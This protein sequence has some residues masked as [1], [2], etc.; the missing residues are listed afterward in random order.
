MGFSPS[1]SFTTLTLLLALPLGAQD[2][3]LVRLRRDLPARG[4]NSA[5]K[6]E[7]ADRPDLRRDWNLWWFGG[8]LSPDYLDYKNRLAAREMK[9]WGALMPQATGAKLLPAVLGAA[10]APAGT[11]G[12]WVNLGPTANLTNSTWPDHDSGRPSAIAVDPTSNTLYLATSGGGVWKCANADPAAATAWTWTPITDGLPNSGSS[13]NVSVGALALSPASAQTVYLGLGDAFDAEGRGFYKSTDGGTT[14]TA[15]TGIGA[16]TRSYEILALDANVVLW[17]TNDGLKRSSNGGTSFVPVTGGPATGRAWS[18]QAFSATEL[19]CS[20]QDSNGAGSLYYS[21]DAGAS[22]TQATVSGLGTMTPG[23][24]TLATV[25]NGTV[26]YAEVED[27][28]GGKVGRGVLVTA[29]KGHTW[30]W[31]AAAT[32]TGGL[33][34]GTGGSMSTDGG[35]EWYNQAIAVDPS[36]PSR[37]I[38]GANLAMYRST[39]GGA[40][41]Q[42]LTHWYGSGHVYSHADFHT[43]TAKGGVF[44]VGN[45][46]GLSI[47]KDP[48]RTTIPTTN[49]DLTFV[50]STRNLGLATHLVYNVGSTTATNVT[51]GKYRISLGL[52]DNGTRIR[53]DTGSGL[54]ASSTFEDQIGG[55]GFG[56][57][58]NP[59]DGNQMLGSIYYTQIYKST[60]GGTSQFTSS[61]SGITETNNSSKAPFQPR[62]VLGDTA[63]PN[64]VY[65]ATNGTVYQSTNFGTSWTGLGRTGLPAA[66]TSSTSDPA[67]A[68]YI[69]NLG[70][71]AGD[72]NALGIAA[73]QGRIFL[74]YNGGSSWTQA[75]TL[76]NNGSYTS[77]LWFDRTNAQTVYAASVAPDATKNHLWKSTNGGTSWSTLDGSAS[78]SNGFPFG[79]PVHVVV[80]DPVNANTVYA[81][82]DFGVYYSIDGGSNWARFGS[83]LPMVAVRDLYIAPDGSFLRAAT[84]GRGVWEL[85]AAAA[86]ITV[87]LDKATATVAPSGTTTFT[88]AVTNFKTDNTVNWTVS[89]SGGSL[90]P[91]S[92]ASGTATTYTAPATVGLYTVTAASNES[93]SATASATVAVYTP[94]SVT[95]TVS[96]ATK[97]LLAGASFTFTAAVANAPDATVTWSATGGTISSTGAYKAPT[98]PGTYTV[99]ATSTWAG[100]TPGIATVTVKTLDL[101]GDGTVDQRDLLYF[102]KYYGTANATCD[103]NGDGVV[104]DSDLALL[105]GGL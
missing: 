12:T 37:L 59:A 43:I 50:D 46:G 67:N 100:T 26:G 95:V 33:F 86:G 91:A 81:G 2:R 7:E 78:T 49:P 89:T 98:T 94:A 32:E 65:T 82:T 19:V 30:T 6:G 73:N 96:P 15:S 56:T 25:P 62:L 88:A 47:F 44:Y 104:D 83:G 4:D 9:H 105:L 42:Q 8:K 102:A 57:V 48:W 34:Q 23:R 72:P 41:W 3:D 31:Q 85:Q 16:Q 11:G 92:T 36:N 76:T 60:N 54:A 70:A 39:N 90:S 45:D 71:A 79:I 28:T 51:D 40:N 20:A 21:T 1:R 68:L 38:M 14:W 35:Q 17:G 18:I 99:T 97:T 52:Q 84:F 24:M 22:W 66:G 61:S 93:P 5:L 101:N 53:Q 27:T 103:L 13:G 64:T 29:D 69:R 87:A 55:D 74:S 10:A 80:T 58:V 75:G 63:H 77:S